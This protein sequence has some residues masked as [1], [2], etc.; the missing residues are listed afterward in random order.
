MSDPTL[1]TGFQIGAR[2]S[3]SRTITEADVVTFAG[4]TGNFA[5]MHIDAEYARQSRFGQ[6]TVPD[7]LASGLV[8]A[9]LGTRLPGPGFT[10][11]SFHLEFL[12]P[13]YIGDTLTAEVE[14][15]AW[16]PEKRL[17]T[18]KATCTNQTAKQVITG[19]AVLISAMQNQAR[20]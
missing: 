13:V 14:V 5:P 9:V 10:C 16:Q 6:R 1:P 4:L 8:S 18:L 11:L 20:V 12:A 2:A 3:L 7:L 17:L 15:S 19:Q